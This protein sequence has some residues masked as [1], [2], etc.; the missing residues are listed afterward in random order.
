MDHLI[1]RVRVK[2]LRSL[3]QKKVRANEG[4]L[5]VEGV[6]VVEEAVACGCAEE[7]YFS[8]EALDT[9]LG[10]RLQA[11]GVPVSVLGPG[12]AVKLRE[13]RTPAGVFA[14]AR[15]PVADFGALRWEA[16]AT[17][18]VA[19]GVA[20]PG[21]FGT[22]VRSAAALGCAGVVVTAG[23]VEPT[24]PKAVR[25]TAGAIFRLPVAQASR[26]T[27]REAGFALWVA[28]RAGEPLGQITARP[29]RVALLVGNEPRGVD[30]DAHAEA[31]RAVAIPL[32]AGV[33]SLNVAVAAGILLHAIG[34]MAVEQ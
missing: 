19:D 31:D 6:N 5:L 13:T 12:D 2:Y 9:E 1:S 23:S 4:R 3:G 21:N 18:L 7:L 26:T 11:S 14:L 34:A 10:S 22:L 33:E 30:A 28:D 25:A 17:L 15:S 27:V 32:A 20:D 16:R 8:E 24:N 29:P